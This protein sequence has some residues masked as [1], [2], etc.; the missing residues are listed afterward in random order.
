MNAVETTPK[1]SP[2]ARTSW[3][4]RLALAL[5]AAAALAYLAVF[6]LDLYLLP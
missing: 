2:V 6:A 1:R 4:A 5:W 3:L